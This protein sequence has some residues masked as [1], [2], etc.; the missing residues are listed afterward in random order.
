ML[1]TPLISFNFMLGYLSESDSSPEHCIGNICILGVTAILQSV[2]GGRRLTF[3]TGLGWAG[4]GWAGRESPE[5]FCA[6]ATGA[7][8]AEGGH[9][10]G[11]G[12]TRHTQP[13]QGGDGFQK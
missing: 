8:R 2:R 7:R 9:R 11:A 13:T 3:S 5:M 1:I 4:L 10:G 12:V 6:A